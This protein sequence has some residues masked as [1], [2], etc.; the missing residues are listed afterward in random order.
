MMKS[1][2]FQKVHPKKKMGYDVQ[3]K[4]GKVGVLRWNIKSDELTWSKSL[5]TIHNLPG[6]EL[7]GNFQYFI[8]NI[9]AFDKERFSKTISKFAKSKKK[10]QIEYRIASPNESIRYLELRGKMRKINNSERIVDGVII[11]ISKRKKNERYLE[12]TINRIQAILKNLPE[13][14]TV[15]LKSGNIVYS[16]DAASKLLEV[17]N[18][19]ALQGQNIKRLFNKF[20]I[21]TQKN[22]DIKPTDLLGPKLYSPNKRRGKIYLF[23]NKKTET[24]KWLRI[25]PS[26]VE[27]ESLSPQLY[28]KILQDVSKEME[29]QQNAQISLG[30][31]SH[32]LKNALTGLNAYIHLAK[33]R[34]GMNDFT[35]TKAYL[36]SLSNQSQRVIKLINDLFDVSRIRL[37]F[38]KL[39]KKIFN[40]S[41]FLS[42]TVEQFKNEYPTY[43]FRH[44]I[45]KSIYISADRDRLTQVVINLLSNAIKYSNHDNKIYIKTSLRDG[46]VST[47]IKDNGL[48]IP[49]NKQKEIFNLYKRIENQKTKNIK[50]LGVGLFIT[51]GI[52]KAHRGTIKVKSSG[53]KGSTFTF[54]IPVSK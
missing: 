47:S 1:V 25:I 44:N 30:V 29:E 42:N 24:Y 17:K 49:K 2:K 36:D 20:E 4:L 6:K 27:S 15:E 23:S 52:I 7:K 48:G 50:G 9:H 34:I 19:V 12:K 3:L 38:L 37:G 33:R 21:K 22:T 18:A 14:I 39:N 26:E 54:E 43:D 28:I 13:G 46:V 11:D 32:E 31:T 10:F 5:I 16:N 53:E 40:Y 45:N 51:K 41:E 8:Q 35:G